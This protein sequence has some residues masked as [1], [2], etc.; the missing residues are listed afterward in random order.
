MVG[1][2]FTTSIQIFDSLGASHVTTMTYTNTGP[3]RLDVRSERRR[4]ETSQAAPP[5]RRSSW[6][7]GTLSFDGTGVLDRSRWRRARKRLDY[8]AGLDQRRHGEHVAAGKW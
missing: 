7:T 4:R 8:D 3:G 5:A 1:D 6:P 2:T